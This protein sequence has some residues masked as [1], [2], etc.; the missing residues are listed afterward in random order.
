MH[1]FVMHIFVMHVLIMHIFV[2]HI[3]FFKGFV[4]SEVPIV[5]QIRF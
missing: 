2:M 3:L 5:L 1:I 4:L